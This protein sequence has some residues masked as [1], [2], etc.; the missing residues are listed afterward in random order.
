MKYKKFKYSRTIRVWLLI[1]LFMIIGQVILGGITR[2]TGSGLSITKWDVVTGVVPPLNS[3]EW[4]HEFEL[5]KATPQFHKINSSFTLQDFKFIYFWE[6]FHRLWVRTLG[7]IFLIPFLIFVFTKKIDSYLIKRLGL[8]VLLTILTASAGWIMV[9]SGLINRPWVNAYK[10]T[11][12]FVLAV[13]V[14]AAMVRTVA[15][16]YVVKSLKKVKSKLR[17]IVF[18]GLILTFIQL[19]VAG[20]ISGMRAGLYYPTWPDMN[21]EFVPAV[22]LNLENWSWENMI[23]YDSYLFAPA[24]IQFT[25]RLLAYILVIYV[26]YMFVKLKNKIIGNSKKWMSLTILLIL[27]Q[28]ALGILTVINV[29]GKIPL[30]FGVAHQLVGTL[31]FTS[32]LFLYFSLR[33][34]RV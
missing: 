23:N 28:V 32:F 11:L 1:G 9:K 17:K 31:F 2:L 27:I 22:L 3:A 14:I 30:F 19:I 33:N 25:H 12:H 5:Y 13:L 34:K 16:V 29:K 7:F 20:L 21:G 8:V 4:T 15:D 10:L 6:Y 26:F 18:W 24:L